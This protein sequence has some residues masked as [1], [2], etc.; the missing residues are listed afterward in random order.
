MLAGSGSTM[1]AGTV[2]SVKVARRRLLILSPF[3]GVCTY[4]VGSPSGA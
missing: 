1:V 3:A 4:G 2:V